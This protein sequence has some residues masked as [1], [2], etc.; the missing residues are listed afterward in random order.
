DPRSTERD[1]HHSRPR[2]RSQ[3]CWAEA[4]PDRLDSFSLGRAYL[5]TVLAVGVCNTVGEA[6]C[7][8]AVGLE[9]GRR[10]LLLEQL[11]R[12]GDP[13]EA[14][15]AQQLGRAVA[16]SVVLGLRGD[17]LVEQLALAVLLSRLLVGLRD[18]ERLAEAA[19]ALGR[20]HDHPG[21]HGPLRDELPLLL[22]E[23]GLRR[24]LPA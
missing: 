6:E 11:R 24:H 2:R 4:R 12:L 17:E 16:V 7:E 10:G 5:L 21:R 15:F 9:L 22:A 14:L 13:L 18:R 3:R 20:E 8:A 1:G 19:A 23:V